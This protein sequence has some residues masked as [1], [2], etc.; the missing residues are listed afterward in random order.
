MK[1]TYKAPVINNVMVYGNEPF[2]SSSKGEPHGSI[3][4]YDGTE[5]TPGFGTGG[6]KGDAKGTGRFWDDEE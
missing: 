6:D 1:K 2:M 3:S 4:I 5:G